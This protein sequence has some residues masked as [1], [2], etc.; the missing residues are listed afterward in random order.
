MS[1]D[2]CHLS[3]EIA[4]PRTPLRRA[5]EIC[6]AELGLDPA[7]LID[8]NYT[9][10]RSAEWYSKR[11]PP[12]ERHRWRSQ[13]TLRFAS[14]PDWDRTHACRSEDGDA[15]GIPNM[16][17]VDDLEARVTGC[18]YMVEDSGESVVPRRWQSRPGISALEAIELA[19]QELG[20][21]PASIV[22]MAFTSEARPRSDRPRTP[23]YWSLDFDR[24]EQFDPDGR[25]ARAQMKTARVD[26]TG[27][28]SEGP[29]CTE[30][31]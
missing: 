14:V 29:V 25:P 8:A 5:L 12:Y 23:G 27:A 22:R 13:W 31:E 17:W 19:H 28:V 7:E 4:R 6:V 16:F 11:W 2:E 9:S 30:E 18:A 10:P 20:L 1:E 3:D 24:L 21:D 26:R 15:P